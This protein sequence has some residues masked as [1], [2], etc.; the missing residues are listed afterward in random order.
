MPRNP[1]IYIPLWERANEA[2]IGI[3]IETND[4]K[5]LRAELYKARDVANRP[6][7]DNIIVCMPPIPDRVFMCHKSAELPE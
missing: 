7:F 3:Y 2:E 1:N 6:E 4:P 5:T